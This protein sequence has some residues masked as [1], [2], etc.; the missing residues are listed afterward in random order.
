MT[1]S[2]AEA[3]CPAEDW[4]LTMC[5][6]RACTHGTMFISDMPT[7]D[8]S[9]LAASGVELSIDGSPGTYWVWLYHRKLGCSVVSSF[10]RIETMPDIEITSPTSGS[11]YQSQ[12]LIGLVFKVT[13]QPISLKFI[14]SSASHPNLC[15]GSKCRPS[16]SQATAL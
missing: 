11:T 9:E 3:S 16:L 2:M 10:R 6:I 8:A 13:N 1:V 5:A 4:L 7:P 15:S 12:E 14:H